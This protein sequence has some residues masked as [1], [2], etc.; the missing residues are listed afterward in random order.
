MKQGSFNKIFKVGSLIIKISKE[1]SS[2]TK[3]IAKMGSEDI[4]KYEKDIRETGVDTSKVYLNLK[5]KDKILILQKYIDGLTLQDFFEKEDLSNILKLKIFKELILLYNKTKVNDN[6]CLD[7]N[8]KNFII[9]D[10]KIVY[11]D[12]VPALYKD[13][14]ENIRHDRLEQ[15]IQSYLDRKIQLAGIISYAIVPFFK[16]DKKELSKIFYSMITIIK[17]ILNIDLVDIANNDHVY[18]KKMEIINNYLNSEQEY[19]SFLEDYKSISMQKT[20]AKRNILIKK[21][22]D[23]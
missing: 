6:L 16:E 12:Y 5:M 21:D 9:Y 23:N 22:G 15:Y 14:I 13:K 2:I 17:E 11:I 20:A 18:L 19:D 10:N 1:H 8:L 3:E 4:K 7:W